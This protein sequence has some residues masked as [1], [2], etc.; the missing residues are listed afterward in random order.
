[1]A[2][3]KRLTSLFKGECAA[4]EVY[5]IIEEEERGTKTVAIVGHPFRRSLRIQRSSRRHVGR[6]TFLVVKAI[7]IPEKAVKLM[8]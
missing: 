5:H 6:V 1:M 3:K 8:Q 4:C 2:C 7:S